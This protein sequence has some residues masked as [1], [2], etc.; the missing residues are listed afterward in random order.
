[1]ANWA[2][3]GRR[4]NLMSGNI[5]KQPPNVH[6]VT[7]GLI[8]SWPD[9]EITLLRLLEIPRSGGV[10]AELR[11][12]STSGL[13]HV[14]RLDLLSSRARREVVQA[15]ELRLDGIGKEP[16][17][18]GML[19]QAC[20][21]AVER[22]R[23]GD[24]LVDL[25]T[26]EP[27][28]TVPSLLPPL[29]DARGANVLFADG[30]TGKSLF[31]LAVAVTVATGV[32]VLGL[33]PAFTCPVLYWDWEADAATHAE[34][35]HAICAGLDPPVDPPTGSILYRR[36]IASLAESAPSVRRHIADRNIGFAVI[37]SLG[38][39]RGGEPESGDSTLRTFAAIRSLGIPTLIQDHVTKEDAKKS[40]QQKPIGSAYTWNAARRVWNL[41]TA[42]TAGDDSLQVTLR[43]R[44]SNFSR[45]ALPLAYRIEFEVGDDERLRTVR[46]KK[47][48]AEEV[49][50][51][52]RRRT[53][54][55]IIEDILTAKGALTVDEIRMATASE[56]TPMA[57][58]AIRSVLNR[59][60]RR[61]V[62]RGGY[63]QCWAAL[64][65]ADQ[66]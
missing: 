7:D 18:D 54:A 64:A 32:P 3:S 42:Q 5:P 63:P 47:A 27:E 65:M 56:G 25:A 15:V 55:E 58:N 6:R 38:M 40:A 31:G 66:E 22:Y 43:N 28:A 52:Q 48:S 8:F 2:G 24:P 36:E 39:A 34:R 1:M 50:A 14:G 35:L 19:L 13:L 11:V 20:A 61:F 17:F 26:V 49:T 46:F 12:E 62:N 16:D 10:S 37:D 60:K 29:L 51:V 30:G 59:S 21:L 33:Q 4:T 9:I 41:A 53:Q 57:T 44:K 23:E 45:L